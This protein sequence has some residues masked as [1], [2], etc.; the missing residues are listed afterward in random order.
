MS[1]SSRREEAP[2]EIQE[3]KFEP[4]NVGSYDG[5]TAPPR[6]THVLP[7]IITR[8]QSSCLSCHA[9]AEAEAEADAKLSRPLSVRELP[10]GQKPPPDPTKPTKPNKLSN[11]QRDLADRIEAALGDQWINDA[12]KW[13]SRIKT[14]F[15]KTDRVI[16]EV[17]NARKEGRIA[18]TPAQFAEDTWGRFAG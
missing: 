3:T 5:T 11:P 15:G 13:I 12:G 10:I 17:E 14:R 18:T 7:P 6:V 1:C 4:P 8:H 2:S 16:A 9:E